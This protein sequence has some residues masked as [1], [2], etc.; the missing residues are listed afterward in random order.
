MRAEISTRLVTTQWL[1]A[2]L[3]FAVIAYYF[4]F[5][6]QHAINIPFG[7]DIYDVLKVIS[8]VQLADDKI[9]ALQILYAP[10]NEHRTFASRLLYFTTYL[11]SGQVD[12]RN[13]IFLANLAIPLLFL[14]FYIRIRKHQMRFWIL[15]PVA[16]ILFQL[17]TYSLTLWSMAAFAYFYVFLYGFYSLYC[18]HELTKIKFLLAVI[19]ASLATF[20]LAS[21]QMI[22][23]AGFACLVHQSLIRRD[24]SILYAVIWFIIGFV[25]LVEL[26]T[27]G[28]L[29]ML[30][31][32]FSN[33]TPSIQFAL[34]LLGSAVSGTSK[35]WAMLAG[36]T[37]LTTLTVLTVRSFRESDLRLEFCCWFVVLSVIVMT[38]G[39]AKMGTPLHSRYSF[40]SVLLLAGV[41]VLIA[42][43]LKIQS[44]RVF[45]PVVLLACAY[46]ITSYRMYGEALQTHLVQRVRMFNFGVYYAFPHPAQE[47]TKIVQKA[48]ENEIYTP[49]RRPLPNP[50]R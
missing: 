4:G 38:I 18:L 24:T 27:S 29:N 44:L 20:T 46:C 25:L 17:R 1:P 45:I 6:Y 5:L 31:Y 9:S 34:A 39:R 7:D 35:G 10:H 37:L 47:S 19:L 8:E 41:W 49:P 42:V 16:L 33:P 50:S 32:I 12:F 30:G 3:I 40:P 22:W 11:V 23:L 13:L 36:S 14:I 21:G 43:R 15:L 26:N 48:I 2:G 28:R